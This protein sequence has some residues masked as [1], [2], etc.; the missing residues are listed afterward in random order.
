MDFSISAL[1]SEVLNG[2]SAR[3]M[4]ALLIIAIF[5]LIQEIRTQRKLVADLATKIDAERSEALKVIDSMQ[6]RFMDKSEGML[7]K[8]HTALTSQHENTEKIKDMI[9]NMITV[10][11][12]KN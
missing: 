5:I 9:T 6:A 8:Y 12:S 3:A 7:D 11:S 1:I 10:I 4:I 2:G